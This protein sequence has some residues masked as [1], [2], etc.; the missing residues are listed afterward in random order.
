MNPA[1]K[2]VAMK[3][4]YT[5][6]T[7]HKMT[8]IQTERQVTQSNGFNLLPSGNLNPFLIAEGIPATLT[9]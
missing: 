6:G 3:L 7:N 8:A 2:I 1:P 5:S 9:K 4:T